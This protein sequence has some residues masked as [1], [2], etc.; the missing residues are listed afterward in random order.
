LLGSVNAHV[1]SY[2]K[3]SLLGDAISELPYSRSGEPDGLG[4]TES[5][6]NGRA[7]QVWEFI[8]KKHKRAVA[9]ALI[10]S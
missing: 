2:V 9:E 3:S 8:L 4:F 10:L 6:R 1:C 5:W 7:R